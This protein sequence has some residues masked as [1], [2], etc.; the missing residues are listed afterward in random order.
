MVTLNS[1]D[2][3]TKLIAEA[4]FEFD[5][6]AICAEED[7][8]DELHDFA[9]EFRAMGSSLKNLHKRV[10]GRVEFIDRRGLDFMRRARQIRYLIP[11]FSLIQAIDIACKK[12]VSE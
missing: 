6:L 7:L 1:V 10:C 12:G 8:D 11:F 9:P 2:A 4:I 5:E 3:L